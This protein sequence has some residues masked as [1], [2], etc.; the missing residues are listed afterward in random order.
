MPAVA[1]AHADRAIAP[2]EIDAYVAEFQQDPVIP[3]VV[4]GV[5]GVTDAEL[6]A[7]HDLV[8]ATHAAG[9]PETEQV[10]GEMWSDTV[11]LP[12]GVDK[13]DADAAEIAIATE[14]D[15]LSNI[16]ADFRGPCAV[17]D[18]CYYDDRVYES[19]VPKCDIPFRSE[20]KQTCKVAYS[21]L[22][23]LTSR[24]NC[25]ATADGMYTIVKRV[26]AFK[27]RD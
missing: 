3:P 12:T 10:P 24:G 14:Q 4:D 17:H 18:M 2:E 6:A 16:V 22:A 15:T 23:N 5:G 9:D 27:H 21:P 11:G 26:Q 20:L 8:R 13:T 19:R 1:T 7:Y 25:M